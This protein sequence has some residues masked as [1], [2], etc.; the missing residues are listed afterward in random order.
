MVSCKILGFGAYKA[1]G[2]Q[3][4]GSMGFTSGVVNQCLGFTVTYQNLHFCRFLL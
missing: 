1:S 3:D 2:L 4:L